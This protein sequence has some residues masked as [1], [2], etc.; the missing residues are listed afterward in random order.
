MQV[1]PQGDEW[2]GLKLLVEGAWGKNEVWWIVAEGYSLSQWLGQ[3]QRPHLTVETFAGSPAVGALSGV[4]QAALRQVAV[5]QRPTMPAV[6]SALTWQPSL[7]AVIVADVAGPLV[8]DVA[9]GQLADMART[10]WPGC[11]KATPR[12]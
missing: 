3:R 1:D 4:Q 2:C 12:C 9:E 6:H 11:W 7:A 8:G 5:L 10:C